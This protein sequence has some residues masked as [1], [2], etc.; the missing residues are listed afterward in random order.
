MSIALVI[1]DNRATADA[2]VQMLEVLGLTARTAYGSSA[3]MGVLAAM[4]PELILLDINMPGVDGFEV[5]VIV[6][7][8]EDQRENLDRAK[9]GGAR[10]WVTKPATLDSLEAALKTAGIL[11]EF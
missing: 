10:A 11:E 1:D 3:A 9:K 4:T 5:P 8:S 6:I 2:L 7:S